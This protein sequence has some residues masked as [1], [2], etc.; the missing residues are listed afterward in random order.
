MQK[1]ILLLCFGGMPAFLLSQVKADS[2]YKIWQNNALPD[3]VRLKAIHNFS[4]G[5]SQEA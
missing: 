5:L 2:L 3:T 1:I 4:I